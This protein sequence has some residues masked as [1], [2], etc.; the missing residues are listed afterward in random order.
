M[1]TEPKSST[2]PRDRRR[3]LL[4]VGDVAL[5]RGRPAAQRLD[6]LRGRLGVDE[7]LRAGDL[8]ERPVPLGLL[9]GRLRLDLDV[10]DDDVR[11]GPGERQRVGAAEPARAAGDEGDAAGEVDL[12]RHRL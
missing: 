2:Q 3:D 4:A 11:A 5:D 8:R 9:V 7:P 6:L 1:S 12:E 10:G